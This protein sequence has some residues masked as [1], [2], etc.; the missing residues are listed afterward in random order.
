VSSDTAIEGKPLSIALT[1]EI[2]HRPK[3]RSGATHRDIP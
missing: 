3:A 1:I 2:A